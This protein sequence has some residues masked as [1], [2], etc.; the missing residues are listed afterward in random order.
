MTPLLRSGI[1]EKGIGQQPAPAAR[2]LLW[3]ARRTAPPSPRD[4]LQ[5]E[6]SERE[7]GVDPH[8]RCASRAIVG[9]DPI[10]AIRNSRKRNRPAAGTGGSPL[11]MVGAAHGAALAKG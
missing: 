3:S 7:H 9:D 4:K 5:P 6:M 11:I 10:A 8:R 1:R 2:L